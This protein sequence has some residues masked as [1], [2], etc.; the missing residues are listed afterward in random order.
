MNVTIYLED[1]L[2][3][4]LTHWAKSSGQNRNAI[5][6]EAIQEWLQQR[7]RQEWPLAV[8]KFNGV[9]DFPAFET[10]RDELQTHTEDPFA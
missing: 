9:A 4:E 5:I 3:Q 6:R 1:P 10:Y 7:K 2:A 8:L